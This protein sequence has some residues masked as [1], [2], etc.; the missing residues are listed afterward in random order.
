MHE[1]IA[2]SAAADVIPA[3]HISRACF[4]NCI[5]SVFIH[6]TQRPMCAWAQ[7]KKVIVPEKRNLWPPWSDWTLSLLHCHCTQQHTSKLS[8]LF[9]N[10]SV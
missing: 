9:F 4:I 8:F 3:E 7:T 1:E 5:P 6:P 2:C 10:Q